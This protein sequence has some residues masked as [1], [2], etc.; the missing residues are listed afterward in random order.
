MKVEGREWEVEWREVDGE[1]RGTTGG[2]VDF[3]H[4][5]RRLPVAWVH[6]FEWLHGHPKV[7]EVWC[8]KPDDICSLEYL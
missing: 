5:G 2:G 8:V 7:I 1:H 4:P 6:D 3:F